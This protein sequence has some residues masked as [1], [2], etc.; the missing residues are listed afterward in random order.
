[1]FSNIQIYWSQIFI[2]TFVRVKFCAWICSD[3]CLRKFVDTNAYIRIFVGVEMFTSVTLWS[4]IW[5]HLLT[6]LPWMPGKQ[7][8]FEQYQLP[9]AFQVGST[10]PWNTSSK[11]LNCPLFPYLLSV[12][13]IDRSRAT[14][15]LFSQIVCESS[16]FKCCLCKAIHPLKS[17]PNPPESHM[18][19][20]KKV[21]KEL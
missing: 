9:P 15:L 7:S 4:R 19:E 2:W 13:R 16:P 5:V 6:L 8:N 17:H 10:T 21:R 1:M 12:T 20:M 11:L 3:I 18:F 14:L